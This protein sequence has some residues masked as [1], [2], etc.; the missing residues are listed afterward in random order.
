MQPGPERMYSALRR[1]QRRR[2]DFR[3]ETHF[4]SEPMGSDDVPDEKKE[5]KRALEE[6]S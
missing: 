2:R 4:R 3:S 6:A 1:Y 5:G